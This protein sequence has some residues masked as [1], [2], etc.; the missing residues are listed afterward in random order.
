MGGSDPGELIRVMIE[1]RNLA[2]R[3]L[4][5]D[6][7]LQAERYI[8]AGERLSFVLPGFRS[9]QGSTL[10]VLE[11]AKDHEKTWPFTVTDTE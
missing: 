7:W 9:G 3:G 6:P 1:R 4:G 2:P 11:T 5:T 10:A 8:E